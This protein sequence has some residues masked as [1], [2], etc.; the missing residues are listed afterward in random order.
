MIATC[1]LLD[2]LA[3]QCR[4]IN[5]TK[6]PQQKIKIKPHDFNSNFILITIYLHKFNSF[7]TSTLHKGKQIKSKPGFSILYG[8]S[9]TFLRISERTHSKFRMFKLFTRK[10]PIFS[11]GIGDE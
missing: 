11:L 3:V 7:Q 5:V 1:N 10:I 9:I 4:V 2:T 6:S 8:S